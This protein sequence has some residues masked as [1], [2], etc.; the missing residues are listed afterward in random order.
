MAWDESRT[1]AVFRALERRVT[2]ASDG[3]VLVGGARSLSGRV[4][5][6]VRDSYGYRWLTA[7]PDP[8]VVVIDLR[9]TP[10]VGPFVRLLEQVVDPV[11]R[12]WED[13]RIAATV[14]TIGAA[15]AD[16]RTGQLLAALLE[17]PEPPEHKNDDET[18]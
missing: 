7:E 9:E 17:P 2:Q 5:T 10:T 3:S 11:E 13:S 18:R 6:L 12:A 8:S 15:L 16:S 4:E 1:A 14:T